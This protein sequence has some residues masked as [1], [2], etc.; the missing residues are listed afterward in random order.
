MYSSFFLLV[1]ELCLPVNIK[2]MSHLILDSSSEVQKVAYLFLQSAAKK[3]TEYFVIEA[4]VDAEAIV[5]ADLPQQILDIIQRD[6]DLKQIDV[7]ETV[8][9][10]CS[11]FIIILSYP[12]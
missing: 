2:Q 9:G 12:L 11:R 8:S 6:L 5:K 7:Q 1:A 3:R 4:G 10:A